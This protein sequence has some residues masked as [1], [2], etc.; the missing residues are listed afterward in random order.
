[1]YPSSHSAASRQLELAHRPV[2]A[3][4]RK[5]TG[6]SSPSDD[7]P[8]VPLIIPGCVARSACEY[9]PS[10]ALHFLGRRPTGG[11]GWVAVVSGVR[12]VELTRR[13]R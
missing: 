6:M 5:R 4:G 1:M 11:P 12:D 13:A 7:R 10:R 8:I 9:G 2:L 3:S